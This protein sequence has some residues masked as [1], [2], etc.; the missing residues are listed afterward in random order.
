MQTRP[1]HPT[2][3][4]A[5]GAF[6][7]GELSPKLEGDKALQFRV[8]IAANLVGMVANELRTQGERG[9]S[10]LARLRA[11]LGRGDGELGALNAELALRLREG[12][13]AP[14]LALEHLF[15]TARETLAV[16]NPRFDLDAE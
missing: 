9:A 13:L 4:E 11:L 15:T 12:T 6:L 2:L 3:L 5:V 14:G 10:E 1:D 16:T 8:L 7:L